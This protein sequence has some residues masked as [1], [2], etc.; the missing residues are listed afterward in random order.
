[1]RE[2]WFLS[3]RK[4][5]YFLQEPLSSSLISSPLTSSSHSAPPLLSSPL[6]SP[7]FPFPPLLSSL[8]FVLLEIESHSSLMLSKHSITELNPDPNK[9]IFCAGQIWKVPVKVVPGS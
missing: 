3:T 7:P 8:I 4:E 1:M 6:S 5:I 2:N 9:C